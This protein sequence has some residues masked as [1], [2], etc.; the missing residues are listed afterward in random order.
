VF[1]IGHSAKALPSADTRQRKKMKKAEKI[2][3]KIWEGLPIS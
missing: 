3:K 1:F 2:E